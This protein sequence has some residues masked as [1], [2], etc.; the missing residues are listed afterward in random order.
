MSHFED[1]DAYHPY[2]GED[3]YDIE[4]D[5]YAEMRKRFED[6][7]LDDDEHDLVTDS[8]EEPEETPE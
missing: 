1:V 2:A 3:A 5:D 7:Y 4:G 6:Q 8:E